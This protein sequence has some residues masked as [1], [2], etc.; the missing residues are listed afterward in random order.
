MHRSTASAKPRDPCVVSCLMASP[1]PPRSEVARERAPRSRR[2]GRPGLLTLALGS[3]GVVF[4]D[5]G[6]SPLYAFREAIA[7]A[8]GDDGAA[9]PRR[10]ARRPLADP[11]DADAHRLD[12]IRADP[13]AR[14]QPRRRRN[15]FADGARAARPRD[16]L[17]DGSWCSASS[18]R[19]SSTA[20]RR[21]RRRSRCFR[22][23]KV[24][25][26]PRRSLEHVVLPLTLVIL[27]ALFA[28]QRTGTG[29]VSSFFGPITALWFARARGLRACSS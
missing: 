27:V 5:I 19:R 10:G 6:T 25:R 18:A 21:S 3:L 26:S 9:R 14:R 23:S 12:Q 7:A 15:A 29:R 1:H 16:D 11:V 17:R 24:W 22:R 4:G 28:V 20:T 8:T 2:G 13:A